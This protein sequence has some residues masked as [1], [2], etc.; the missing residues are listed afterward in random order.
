MPTKALGAIGLG[1]G[2]KRKKE[3]EKIKTKKHNLSTIVLFLLFASV[4][5]F[6]VSRM[7]NFFSVRFGTGATTRTRQEIQCLLCA[8]FLPP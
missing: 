4:E 3:E 8:V 7:Q 6:F 1:S 2:R 5:R